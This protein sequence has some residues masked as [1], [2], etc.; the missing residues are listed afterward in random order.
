MFACLFVDI[1]VTYL[2]LCFYCRKLRQAPRA[3]L[4]KYHGLLADDRVGTM[5]KPV[6]IMP[7]RMCSA[8]TQHVEDALSPGIFRKPVSAVGHP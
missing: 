2:C 3:L 7:E 4:T 1:V 5:I 6:D 8:V